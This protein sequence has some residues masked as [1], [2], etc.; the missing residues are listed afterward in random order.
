MQYVDGIKGVD[1]PLTEAEK[2]ARKRAKK[3]KE[4]KV[5]LSKWVTTEEKANIDAYLR[6]EAEIK[7]KGK[8]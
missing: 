2:S 7:L 8:E 1:M 3:R 4:G 6:G 5:Y